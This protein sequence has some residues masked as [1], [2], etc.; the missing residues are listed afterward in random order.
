[1]CSL[2]V[3]NYVLSGAANSSGFNA[4]SRSMAH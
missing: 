1:M 3:A 2:K 4:S